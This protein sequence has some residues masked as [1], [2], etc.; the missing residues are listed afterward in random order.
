[1]RY[2]GLDIGDIRIGIAISDENGRIALPYDVYQRIGK[3]KDLR[4]IHELILEKAIDAVV[5]GL[6]RHMNGSL[7]DRALLSQ[8][9]GDKLKNRI[10]IPI[11]YYDERLST[12]A[13]TRALLEADMRRNNRKRVVDKVAAQFI[14]QGYLDTVN[15]H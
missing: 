12:V 9:F 7:G 8:E 5:I 1:M 6:P 2:M 15:K 14:L 11:H 3:K 13:A 10:T 4:Y